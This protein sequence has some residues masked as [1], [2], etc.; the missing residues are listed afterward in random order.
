MDIGGVDTKKLAEDDLA[1]PTHL[2]CQTSPR[3]GPQSLPSSPFRSLTPTRSPLGLLSRASRSSPTSPDSGAA[4][5]NS[6]HLDRSSAQLERNSAHFERNFGTEPPP[7]PHRRR[8][9]SGSGL[10]R[11]LFSV[12]HSLKSSLGHVARPHSPDYV[13]K[14]QPM[15]AAAVARHLLAPPRK[16][17]PGVTRPSPPIRRRAFSQPLQPAKWSPQSSFLERASSDRGS[18][19]AWDTQ[20]PTETVGQTESGS[21]TVGSEQMSM[22]AVLEEQR[23]ERFR[24]EESGTE[25]GKGNGTEETE[26]LS[27]METDD[28]GYFAPTNWKAVSNPIPVPIGGT[29]F[30]TKGIENEDEWMECIDKQ[31]VSAPFWREEDGAEEVEKQV[32]EIPV[33]VQLGTVSAPVSSAPISGA[34][35]GLTRSISAGL[36][37]RETGESEVILGLAAPLRIDQTAEL[38]GVRAESS[39]PGSFAG[40]DEMGLEDLEQTPPCRDVR[41]DAAERS[42]G[43][44]LECPNPLVVEVTSQT[45]FT[46]S[47]EHASLPRE[48][49]QKT[50]SVARA[51]V[52]DDPSFEASEPV[53]Q[54][55]PPAPTIDVTSPAGEWSTGQNSLTCSTPP[56]PQSQTPE[57]T[58]PA[59]ASQ[60]PDTLFPGPASPGALSRNLEA[61]RLGGSTAALRARAVPSNPEE[62]EAQLKE[63]LPS[64]YRDGH[65]IG[66]S[67]S[68]V[69]MHSHTD[70]GEVGQRDRGMS[71]SAQQQFKLKWKRDRAGASGEIDEER[72]QK[73]LFGST[74][75]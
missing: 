56:S 16:L 17:P 36:E 26:E 10:R 13:P 2:R 39:L 8:N 61:L 72:Y 43:F 69:R 45:D 18:P 11:A 46:S 59:P 35:D 50:T 23:L 30:D 22:A 64:I 44:A 28:G 6:A 33:S 9:T 5:R 37:Q 14:P 29:K 12:A 65:F 38:E 19:F 34:S 57:P 52:F 47:P 58:A 68:N 55:R 7:L 25:N 67:R 70:L 42:T 73:A 66:R 63:A 27:E 54:R 4:D 41:I 21:E 15:D 75:N 31:V 1:L 40:G 71:P 74:L 32:T 53:L 60:T 24:S 51:L 62:Y 48:H 20:P 3:P 49:S